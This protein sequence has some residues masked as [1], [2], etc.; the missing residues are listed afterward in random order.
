[1]DSHPLVTD[2]EARRPQFSSVN[3]RLFQHAL[4][5]GDAAG[6]ARVNLGG[7][8]QRPSKGLETGFHDVVGVGPVQLA[9]VQG[10]AA[11]VHDRHKKFLHQLGVIGADFLGGNLEAVTEVRAPG[12]VECHLHQGLIQRCHEMTEAMNAA[13]VAE[14]LS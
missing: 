7:H 12:A 2:C 11:V 3:A 10:E 14:G 5:A 8:A 6:P 9:D 13:S 1:M 4:A